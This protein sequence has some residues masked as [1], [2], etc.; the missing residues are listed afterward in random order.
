MKLSSAL[1]L[2]ALFVIP[3][4]ACDRPNPTK[5]RKAVRAVMKLS[6]VLLFSALSIIPLTACDSAK[7]NKVSEAIRA[8]KLLN[9]SDA[10][11]QDTRTFP[12]KIAAQ[13][14]A[15]MAFRV[16]GNLI[17]MPFLQGEEVQKGQVI[18]QLDDRDA[19]NLVLLREADFE[20]AQADFTRKQQ[21]LI[22]K[23]ISQAQFDNAK[24]K[25]K[26]T[27]ANLAS[28]RDQ[29]SYT[30]LIAPFDGVIA[31]RF[32]DNY[33]TVQATQ[34]ILSMQ[35]NDTLDVVIQV[36][37]SLVLANNKADVSLKYKAVV[38]FS[39]NG[40]KAYPVVFKEFSTQVNSSTQSYEATFS[41]PQP[42]DIDV[43]PGMSAELDLS[44]V[45]QSKSYVGV[46]PLTAVSMND[47]TGKSR[48]WLYD[49]NKQRVFSRVVELGQLRS[50]GVEVVEGLSRGD[51]VVVAGVMHLKEAMRV[52]PLVWQ[53]GI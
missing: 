29:L 9:V 14:Q 28:A 41:L 35:R 7:P 10:L 27:R 12:A 34:M 18:A 23:L 39:L 43:L 19:K 36:P 4:T 42:Q 11:A 1:L 38:R 17:A 15:D 30:Q 22:Q 45:D 53:R 5:V 48:V 26:S 6:S 25:L 52:K 21:L 32:I 37:E 51:V 31:K 47:E 49:G 16:S 40:N 44:E 8:V 50:N 33:Q 24:A 2:S 3:L 46:L 20:L 13:G